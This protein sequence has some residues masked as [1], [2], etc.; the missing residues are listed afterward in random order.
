VRL[1]KLQC[2]YLLDLHDAVDAVKDQKSKFSPSK[3]QL[4]GRWCHARRLM[5]TTYRHSL[6]SG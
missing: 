1:H 4:D 5:G 2:E 3:H 6:H